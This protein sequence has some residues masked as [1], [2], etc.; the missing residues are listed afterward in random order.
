LREVIEK[1]KNGLRIEP[2]T[3]GSFLKQYLNEVVAV[4]NK[5]RTLESYQQV[6][7]DHLLTTPLARKM[8]TELR[9]A[10]I[11]QMLNAIRRAPRTVRNVRAVLRSALNV[12]RRWQYIEVN[13][14]TLVDVPRVERSKAEIQTF[15]EEE[16]RRFLIAARETPFSALYTLAVT[17]GLRQGELLGLTVGDIDLSGRTLR[18]V[19]TLS[20]RGGGK[21]ELQS[22][23]TYS[24]ARILPLS[25]VLL[26]EVGP[27]VDN[28]PTNQFLFT[29]PGVPP[30]IKP[31]LVSYH[32]R[33]LLKT[34]GLPKIRFHDLRHTAATLFALQGVHVRTAQTILGHSS[35]QVTLAI[36]THVT[37]QATRDAIGNL[38][39]SLQPAAS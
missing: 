23:K 31:H 12:A 28:R 6:V 2:V 27:L 16:A 15:T 20:R 24:S 11:Q 10:D 13:P 36:Y 35:P 39:A 18:V 38:A 8:L 25:D 3:L 9:P 22:P 37:T 14:A 4:K 32:F 29:L 33:K 21:W 19:G 5:P 7:N 26:K 34:A 17:L 1:H 30:P